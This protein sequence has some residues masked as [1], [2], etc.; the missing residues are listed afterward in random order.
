MKKYLYFALFL[1]IILMSCGKK[2]EPVKIGTL[3]EYKDPL[4]GF[5]IQ[6]PEEWKQFGQAGKARFYQSQGVFQKF[7]DKGKPGELGTEVVVLISQLDNKTFD[8][9]LEEIRQDIKNEGRI[10]KESNTT[11]LDKN[12]IRF[13]YTIP[14]TTKLNLVGYKFVF[15]SDTLF[16]E[17]GFS[18]FGEMYDAHAAVFDAIFKSFALPKPVMK[19]IEG[20]VASEIF[21]KYETPFFIIN[22]PD[23]L[24]FD[25]VAKGKNDLSI[26]IRA[27]RLDCTIRFD[28]FSAQNLTVEKV[29]EQNKGLYKV[30][31]TSERTIDGLKSLYLNYS[32]VSNIESRAYFVVK[33]DKVIRVTINWFNPQKDIYFPVFE[34]I[35]NLM[36]LK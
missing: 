14:I 20:F 18:G 16:Y 25:N 2:M 3:K 27:D 10:D 31:S 22:Y 29:F 26:Q 5:S 8:D 36:K 13:D 21:D 7:L 1:S 12:A 17:I 15:Q 4:F 6:Y 28:V 35:I 19:T 30:K 34:N 33:N 24:N 11:I 32:P 9:F 23:N